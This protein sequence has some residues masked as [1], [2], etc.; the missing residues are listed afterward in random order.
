MGRKLGLVCIVTLISFAYALVPQIRAD[1]LWTSPVNLSQSVATT[2][3]P[4][5]TIDDLGWIH[6]AWS[7]NGEI[8]HRH[9]RGDGWLPAQRVAAGTDLDLVAGAGGLHMAFANRFGD[10]DD[11]FVVSWDGV[12]WT[13]PVNVS[14][15][16]AASSS[17]RMAVAPGGSIVVVWSEQVSFGATAIYL[18]FSSDGA[19]WSS[20]P[21]PNARGTRPVVAVDAVGNAWVAWQEPFDEGFP[22]EIL[23][24][25]QVDGQWTLPVLVSASPLTNSAFPS[26]AYRLGRAYLAWQES[27]TGGETIV[28]SGMSE[29]NWDSPQRRS[30]V[31]GA[32]APSMVFD[33]AGH[34]HLAWTTDVGA[35]Y[36]SW[37]KKSGVWSEVEDVA[38]PL[39][40]PGS[41]EIAAHHTVHA[42]WLANGPLGN[43]D[44]YY[45]ARGGQQPWPTPSPSP[46]ATATETASPPPA[47]TATPTATAT[48]PAPT[49]TPSPTPESLIVLPLILR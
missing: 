11:I 31:E 6:A 14:Q 39:L 12:A 28:T 7:D 40:S 5:I 15:T 30:M 38:G 24:S 4:R 33:P 2:K 1:T 19:R 22:L 21:V 26:L 17:P 23:F 9:N 43:R 8:W 25:Q 16:T 36:R 41:M 3:S 44:A 37:D 47:Q 32:F 20:F 45:A 18:A 34:V 10:Q 35:Q 29:G 46:T 27:T 42:I 13:L 48:G 49:V